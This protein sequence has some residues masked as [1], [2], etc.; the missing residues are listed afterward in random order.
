MRLDTSKNVRLQSP[1]IVADSVSG[2]PSDTT[3]ISRYSP[4][5]RGIP[6]TRAGEGHA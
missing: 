3:S 5:G 1:A 2:T 4:T 6:G